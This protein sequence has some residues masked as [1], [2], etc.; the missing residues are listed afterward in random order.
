MINS[1]FLSIAPVV[2]GDDRAKMVVAVVK[3][4]ITSDKFRTLNSTF[5]T[6]TISTSKF[7]LVRLYFS[8][9]L[10]VRNISASSCQS[11]I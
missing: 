10:W 2:K 4:S 6:K 3:N 11:D 1:A 9:M 8:E 5:P 7:S